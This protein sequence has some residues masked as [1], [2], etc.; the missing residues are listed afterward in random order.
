[1]ETR[2]ITQVKVFKLRLNDM[3]FAHVEDTKIALAA[4]SKKEIQEFYKDEK[5]PW[6]DGKWGKSFKKD[7]VLEWFNSDDINGEIS[8]RVISIE[9]I[10]QNRLKEIIGDNPTMFVGELTV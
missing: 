4:F 10:D 9:W 1:M 2:T 5:D 3:R 7:S 8:D 6:S